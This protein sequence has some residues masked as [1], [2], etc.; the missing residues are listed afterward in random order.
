MYEASVVQRGA[1]WLTDRSEIRARV[2]NTP[3][4]LP[5]YLTACSH[6]EATWTR[7]STAAKTLPAVSANRVLD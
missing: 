1:G 4:A 2:F 7:S 6:E 3:L 5:A